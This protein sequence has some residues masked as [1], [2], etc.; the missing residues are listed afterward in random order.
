MGESMTGSGV[1]RPQESFCWPH[2][3]ILDSRLS[4]SRCANAQNHVCIYLY[5]VDIHEHVIYISYFIYLFIALLNPVRSKDHKSI[6]CHV[7]ATTLLCWLDKEWLRS[8]VEWIS[9]VFFPEK[10]INH[11]QRNC[12]PASLC[13]RLVVYV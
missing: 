12:I 8:P 5:H 4:V 3:L 2:F 11:T 7:C 6:S 10:K 13:C 1:W 9:C